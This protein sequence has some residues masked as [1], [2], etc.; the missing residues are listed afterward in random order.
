MLPII[1][2]SPQKDLNVFNLIIKDILELV[3]APLRLEF[4]FKLFKNI[5]IKLSCA[6]ILKKSKW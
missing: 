5:S 1:V 3:H 4:L 6:F 2:I